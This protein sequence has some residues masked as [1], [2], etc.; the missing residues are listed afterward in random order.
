M[1]LS[2]TAKSGVVSV[3][4]EVDVSN[5]DQLR[6]AL[7]AQLESGSAELSVDL[8]QVPYIDSTGIGVLVGAAHRAAEKNVR[9]EVVRPQKNVERVLGL[10]GVSADLNVR[11]A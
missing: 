9:F 6:S 8:A 3:A 11:E 4:G 10:L 2:I 1:S 7:D 5:A